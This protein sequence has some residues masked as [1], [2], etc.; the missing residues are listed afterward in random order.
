MMYG[1]GDSQKPLQASMDLV[2]SIVIEHVAALASRCVEREF[3][4]PKGKLTAE[5]I[6]FEIRKDSKKRSRCDELLRLHE[7]I[8]EAKKSYDKPDFFEE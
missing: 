2:E 6:L 1:F 4:N 3:A 7:E 5:D 8:K